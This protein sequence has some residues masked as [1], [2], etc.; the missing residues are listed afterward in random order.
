MDQNK[1]AVTKNCDSL[2]YQIIAFRGTKRV[3]LISEPENLLPCP[4]GSSVL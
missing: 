1:K 4:Y 3:Y 2:Q